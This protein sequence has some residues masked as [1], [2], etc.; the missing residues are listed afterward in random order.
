MR[1][2]TK[3]SWRG[4]AAGQPALAAITGEQWR[5]ELLGLV[6][7]ARKFAAEDQSWIWNHRI[8]W[9]ERVTV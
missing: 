4:L 7:V 2:A 3:V 1:P 5:T 9:D 8:D 6:R